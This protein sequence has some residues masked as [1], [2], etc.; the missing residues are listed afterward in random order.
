MNEDPNGLAQGLCQTMKEERNISTDDDIEVC[1]FIVQNLWKIKTMS[2]APCGNGTANELM[3]DYV[4]CTAL[5]L[6]ASL[7]IFSHC[8]KQDVVH[9]AYN[10]MESLK[11][12]GTKDKCKEC[13][14]KGLER[15]VVLGD[16][17]MLQYIH[18]SIRG[19][20]SI[21][22]IINGGKQKNCTAEN[23]NAVSTVHES[24]INS[25]ISMTVLPP[26]SRLG[27]SRIAQ[28]AA[29]NGEEVWKKWLRK[30][31][32]DMRKHKGQAVHDKIWVDFKKTF[33]K[34]IEGLKGNGPDEIRHLCADVPIWKDGD[35]SNK[36]ELCRDMI[37]IRY[38]IN[39]IKGGKK[40]KEPNIEKLTDIQ[41]YLRCIVGMITMLE[42]YEWH[43]KFG[44]IAEYIVGPV[45]AMLDVYGLNG[46]FEQCKILDTKSLVIGQ[47]LVRDEIKK[48]IKDVK[49]A[50]GRVVSVKSVGAGYCKEE[51]RAQKLKEQEEKNRESV[52]KLF[53]RE[54][55]E[56]LGI[57]TNTS[58]DF[59][60]ELVDEK[61]KEM[62]EPGTNETERTRLQKEIEEIIG[63]TSGCSKEL[64]KKVQE[65]EE[66]TM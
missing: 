66:G 12:L 10:V 43:C 30:W 55:K 19:N 56:E 52:I 29:S 41:S 16:R 21:M 60:M 44:E 11:G 13:T 7:Y 9:R 45:E 24:N 39:G 46:K 42:L 28:T 48:W 54:K 14:Y 63:S 40:G 8:D 47:K 65:G 18:D 17:N 4:R 5:N 38:F 36:K 33:D 37:R 25:I 15:M 3:K 22:G 61:L 62:R 26:K 50:I 53:G 57:L 35:T 23:K 27:Q 32:D 6:W 2:G 20:S 49:G 1:K 51:E 64:G 58:S 59:P 31:F 34:L